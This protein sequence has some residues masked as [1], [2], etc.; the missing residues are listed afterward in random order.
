MKKV[1]ESHFDVIVLKSQ[2][3]KTNSKSSRVKLAKTFFVSVKQVS[4]PQTCNS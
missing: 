2:A 1:I 3:V 4:R